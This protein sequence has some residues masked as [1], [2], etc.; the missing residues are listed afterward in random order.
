M[1]MSSSTSSSAPSSTS[2]APERESGGSAPS[3][4]ANPSGPSEPQSSGGASGAGSRG[5]IGIR[6]WHV[7][8]VLV[9]ASV[10]GLVLYGLWPTLTGAAG[11]NPEEQTSADVPA[12]VTRID[13]VIAQRTSL[14]M[15]AEA[16]GHLVPWRRA[17][18]STETSGRV[19]ERLVDEGD[20]VR[21]G[22]LLIRLD[23]REERIAL[24][25]ARA[26]LV[27]A[28]AEYAVQSS[29]GGA[30]PSDTTV[31][32]QARTRLREAQDAFDA[33]T[34]SREEL[35]EARRR[36][37]SARV[38]AGQ[39]QGAVRAATTGLT[40][41]EQAVQR[42]ELNLSRTRVRAPFTGRVADVAAETGQRL[43]A[44]SAVLTLLDDRRM[45]VEVDVLESDVVSVREGTT[46]RVVV[47][48]L[49][50]ETFDGTV[51]AVN[52]M[53]DP[54]SGTGRVTVALPNPGGRLVA[55]LYTTVRL[56]TD[57]LEDRTVVSEDAVL[58]RQGRDLVFRVEEGRAQWEYV[59][60]G[61]RSGAYVEIE[62]GVSPGDTIA[63]D[64]HFALAHDAPVRVDEVRDLDVR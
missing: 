62:T 31:L 2:D 63:V 9:A 40:Q 11:E 25:E 60:V 59:T 13:A 38:L 27:K 12:S 10:I 50:S 19:V 14:P 43:G 22:D 5:G 45:K 18:L 1:L 26:E 46:A 49:S 3:N 24:E 21:E 61:A 36:Y 32:A 48:S 15:R 58:V 47:P 52:P 7:A 4:G 34:L 55:G 23:D 29:Q 42:A 39:E 37:E 53:V 16:N 8:A 54:Q 17:T 20:R 44:G 33:G 30:A 41:A 6:P 64:G 28:Q 56:E 35:A 51:Y 57:R